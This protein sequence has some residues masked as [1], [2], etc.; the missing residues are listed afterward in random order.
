M[1][2]YF[3]LP[4]GNQPTHM[5]SDEDFNSWSGKKMKYTWVESDL[6]GRGQNDDESEEWSPKWFNVSNPIIDLQFWRP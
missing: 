2:D 6:N 5:G 4:E 3:S 1:L